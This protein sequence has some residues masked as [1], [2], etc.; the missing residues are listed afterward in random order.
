ME[1]IQEA[2]GCSSPYPI[3][4]PTNLPALLHLPQDKAVLS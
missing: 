1:S 2:L 3:L 4:A